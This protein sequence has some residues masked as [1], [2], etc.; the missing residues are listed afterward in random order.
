MQSDLR[1]LLFDLCPVTARRWFD[2]THFDHNV[3]AR[4]LADLKTQF[5]SGAVDAWLAKHP[6][7]EL[8]RAL[9]EHLLLSCKTSS[10]T[11]CARYC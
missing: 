4:L 1:P 11:A 10:T 6:Q 9:L 2:G 5:A 3:T 8:R 7:H